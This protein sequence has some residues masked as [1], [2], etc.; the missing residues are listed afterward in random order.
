[1]ASIY[2]IGSKSKS[3]VVAVTIGVSKNPKETLSKLRLALPSARLSL[4]GVE[5]GGARDLARIKETLKTFALDESW[6][7]YA[8]AVVTRVDR[9]RIEPVGTRRVSLDLGEDD[10]KMLEDLVGSMNARAKSKVLR[11]ALKFYQTL[12]TYHSKGYVIQAVKGN[13]TYHFPKLGD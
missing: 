6:Y 10:W 4:L 11:R 7:R 5:D 13:S 12:R 2:Y 8:G 1:M 3:E 9:V